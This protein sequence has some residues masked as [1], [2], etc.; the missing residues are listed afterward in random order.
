MS[1]PRAL[2]ALL[3]TVIAAVAAAPAA[4]RDGRQ[5]HHSLRAPVTDQNFYFVMADRF[6]NGTTANDHGGPPA[7][8]RGSRA[9]IR[10][11]RAGTT[12]AT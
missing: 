3:I 10:R 7:R 9:S 11:A 5:A 1:G 8:A 2:V 12:V 6:A 4:A